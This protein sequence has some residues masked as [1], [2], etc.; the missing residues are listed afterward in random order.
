MNKKRV[1]QDWGKKAY[2]DIMEYAGNQENC[3]YCSRHEPTIRAMLRYIIGFTTSNPDR[4]ER[5]GTATIKCPECLGYFWF[6]VDE[7]QLQALVLLA[8][9]SHQFFQHPG[10]KEAFLASIEEK[11]D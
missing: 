1:Y 10:V 7:L 3:P 9:D 5:F 2:A 4:S 6:H 8:D 11:E